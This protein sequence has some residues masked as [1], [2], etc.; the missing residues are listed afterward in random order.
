M[1][2]IVILLLSL[3]FSF[4][5]LA[6]SDE[7]KVMVRNHHVKTIYMSETVSARVLAFNDA[8]NDDAFGLLPLFIHRL[9]LSSDNVKISAEISEVNSSSLQVEQLSL[10]ADIEKLSS[11]FSLQTN[12]IYNEGNPYAE[13]I[14]LPYRKPQGNTLEVL[15]SCIIHIHI[16]EPGQEV[17]APSGSFADNSV[18]A[19]GDWFRL[20]VSETGI[21]KLSYSDLEEMGIGVSAI[22]P[23]K[24]RIFGNGNGTVP[25]KNSD[26]RIDDLRETPCMVVGENDGSFDEND[27]ILFYGKSAVKWNFVPFGGYGIFQHQNNPYDDHTYYYLNISDSEG[28]RVADQANGGLSPNVFVDEFTDYAAHENNAVNIL[29]TGRQWYGELFSENTVYEYTFNFP[30]ISEDYPVSLSTNVAAHSTIQ[31]QFDY[32]YGDRHLLEIPVAK[33]IVGTTVYAWTSSPDSTGFYPS[34]DEIVIR[35]EYDRPT[36]TSLGWMN[37]I[38]LNA[39]RKLIFDGPMMD[40]RDHLSIGSGNV[41][42]YSIS[43]AS[44][45]IMV[46]DVTDP[47]SISSPVG[48]HTGTQFVFNSPAEQI[49]EFI[50]FDGSGYLSAEFME[51]VENQNLHAAPPVEYIILTHPDFMAQA[52]RMLLLHHMESN[53]TGMI[54][55]PQEIYNEFSSGKQDPAAIRDF[56]RMLYEKAGP[57]EKPKYLLLLGDASYDYKDRVPNNTNFIPTYQSVEALKLGYSFVTDDFYALLDPGEGINAY[58]K[59]LEIGIGRFPV[60]TVEQADQ[61]VDKVE[62][63][64]TL[65]PQVLGDWRNNVCFIADDEDQNLHYNQAEKLQHMLDTGYHVYNL[66]KI[67]LDAFPQVSSP[68][69]NRYPEVNHSIDRMMEV[70]GLIVNYTGHGG[71]AGLAHEKVLDISTINKWTNIDRLPLFITATC[72]FSRFDDPSLISAGEWV[73]LNP[74]GGGIGLLTTSRLAWADPNFRLNKAVYEFM[75]KQKQG[76][77]YR[78]GDVMRLAKTDQNN[79]TNIKNFVLLGDPAMQLAYPSH[80]VKTLTIND[81]TIGFTFNDTL[82]PLSEVSVH[83]MITDYAGNAMPEFNGV[84]YPTFYDKDVKMS[85]LGNDPGSL[86]ANFYVPGQILHRGKVSVENGLFTFNFF[87]PQNMSSKIDYGKFSYY[88]YDSVSMDDAHGYFRIRAGGE[89]TGAVIDN[90]GPQMDLYMNNTAF[91]TGG[92][93]DADPVFLAYISDEHGINHTGNGIG[94]DITL[95]LDNDPQQTFILNSFYDP[96]L[97]SYKG[98]WLSFPFSGLADGKHVLSLEAWDNMNNVS[99]KTIAFEVNVNGNVSLNSVMNYPNPFHDIT[100]FTFSHNKPGNNF[101]VEVRIFNINGQHIRTLHRYAPAEGLSVGPIQWDGRDYRGNKIGN[102]I[103]VYRIYVTDERGNQ[104]VQTSKLIYT[105]SK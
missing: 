46:W 10:I 81:E 39:R 6:G 18:L 97:D 15:D 90:N 71:E 56:I 67:Y 33:I 41:A 96:D 105:G 95:M 5:T 63:Y 82:V 57:E 59:S 89:N 66:L 23:R 92:Y 77:Y 31:S 8:M 83:G 93:T 20:A 4:D 74:R 84:L 85:T 45:N 9:K 53:L 28:L 50:A 13:L 32:Y 69:G 64:L 78:L 26:E 49:R 80:R 21:H 62:A 103:Y 48:T 68:T 38:S 35:V 102:G 94:K 11:D 37:Y 47:F 12:I 3:I 43:N 36:S 42:E 1:R 60:H 14:L 75:F 104:F 87:M 7:L 79:G 24:I 98:G 100:N 22:D 25:E 27:Y 86:P 40:F 76:E 34:G 16:Q 52:E 30:N 55:T 54:V 73:F 44:D 51:R 72:E 101:D 88:A 19:V 91:V 65:R 2:L 70:G 61:M 29:K 17:R 99:E 58:G